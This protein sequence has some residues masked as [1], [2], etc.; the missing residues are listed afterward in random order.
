MRSKL[1]FGCLIF[2]AIINFSLFGSS[3]RV[4]IFDNIYSAPAFTQNFKKS[5][6]FQTD[7]ST[8]LKIKIKN[9]VSKK[10]KLKYKESVESRDSIPEIGSFYMHDD[11]PLWKSLQQIMI[12]NI[13]ESIKIKEMLDV[14]DTNSFIEETEFAEEFEIDDTEI[15][16]KS[17][18]MPEISKD[19]IEDTKK[20]NDSK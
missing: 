1:F 17:S 8:V 10:S 2:A 16:K 6:K 11:A 14:E 3:E 19:L 5:I 4:S 7:S 15:L 18:S 9:D 12:S 13:R 20:N